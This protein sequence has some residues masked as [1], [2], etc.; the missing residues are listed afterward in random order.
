MQL[1]ILLHL[2]LKSNSSFSGAL[3]VVNV[4]AVVNITPVAVVNVTAVAVNNDA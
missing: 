4:T 3:A 2:H 1:K